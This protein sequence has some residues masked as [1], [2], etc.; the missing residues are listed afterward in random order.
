MFSQCAQFAFRGA[1]ARGELVLDAD[2]PP[3]QDLLGLVDLGH[4]GVRDARHLY[5]AGVEQF[6]QG[7][8]GFGIGHVGI[9]PVV[10]VETDGLHA[11]GD[12]VTGRRPA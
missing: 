3:A 1:E 9:G 12:A 6:G 8:D 10:L 11:E 4:R 5:L 7:A 2:Q